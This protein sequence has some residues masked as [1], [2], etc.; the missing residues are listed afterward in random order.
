MPARS[1]WSTALKIARAGIPV[2]VLDCESDIIQWPR[3]VV[4]HAPTV[5]MLDRLGLLDELKVAG[6]LKQDYQFRTVDGEILAAPNMSVLTPEDTAYPLQPAHA[7]ARTR[8]CD[9]AQ[10][11]AHSR[12]RG[13]LEHARH[14]RRRR[15]TT[16]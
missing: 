6:I 14:G 1:G 5:E 7:A 11:P 9:P 12:H 15:M 8:E 4:Y 13:A 16:A 2:L 3:A 10:F